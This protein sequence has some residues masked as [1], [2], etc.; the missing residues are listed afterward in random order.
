MGEAG[1]ADGYDGFRPHT[2][3]S[4]EAGEVCKLPS[5]PR[6]APGRRRRRDADADAD[7]AWRDSLTTPRELPEETLRTLEARQAAHWIA[8]QL[9][10]GL[11]PSDVMVLSRKR[12]GLLPL[13][14][15][16]RELHIAAQIGEKPI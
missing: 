2:T 1:A 13:Q 15:E 7:A 6:S 5:I 11:Q 14:D 16:L 9:T 12:A 8:Q 3:S 4:A 10:A